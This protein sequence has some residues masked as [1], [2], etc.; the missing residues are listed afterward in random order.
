MPRLHAESWVEQVGKAAS[1]YPWV[2][3]HVR[4]GRVG[5]RQ[6]IH[7][8]VCFFGLFPVSNSYK[9]ATLAEARDY[10]ARELL[11]VL[12]APHSPLRCPALQM[13]LRFSFGVVI[14][15]LLL[16]S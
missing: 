10:S 16:I 13:F 11:S 3:F 7:K 1:S 6:V 14:Q 9:Q 5:W 15:S 4:K 12:K 8:H 2:D